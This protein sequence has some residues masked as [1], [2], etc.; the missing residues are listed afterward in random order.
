MGRN[1]RSSWIQRDG[2]EDIGVVCTDREKLA[3]LEV[4]PILNASQVVTR[5]A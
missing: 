2:E 5:E 3:L 4:C 1:R